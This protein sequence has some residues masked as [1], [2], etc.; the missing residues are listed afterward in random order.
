MVKGWIRL[1]LF[2]GLLLLAACATAPRD[3]VPAPLVETAA[4]PGFNQIRFWGDQP[5]PRIEAKAAAGLERIRAANADRIRRGETVEIDFLALSGGGDN[6]AF[7]A[8]FLNGWTQTGYRPQFQIVTGVSTGAIIAPFAFLGP[9]YDAHLRKAYTEIGPEDV[10][11]AA[12]LPNLIRGPSLASAEP[13]RN[14]INAYTTPSLLREIAVEHRKG[15]RLLVAT[16]NLDAGRSVVWDLGAIAASGNPRSLA[17]FRQVLLASS[18]IPGLLPPV[19]IMVEADGRR[20]TELHADGGVT[21]QV[22]AYQ[23]QVELGQI[24]EAADFDV[25]V[26]IYVIRNGRG[27]P[28]YEPPAKVWYRLMNRSLDVL[29]SHQAMSDI[30]RIFHLAQRDNLR[31]HLALI[32][33]RFGCKPSRPFDQS[34]MQALYRFAETLASSEPAWR[35]HPRGAAGTAGSTSDCGGASGP[36]LHDG[37]V[38]KSRPAIE[39]EQNGGE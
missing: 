15:R 22:F 11:E 7:G 20:F 18:A 19:E 17:L 14:L 3:P 24:L 13:L 30:D 35:D 21:S 36:S 38:V 34:Y 33:R 27:V 39:N 12:L 4:A 28:L 32:P 23:S 26:D 16:T 2:G 31:F 8:G 1:P 9:R 37:A 6:G 29:L 25:A 5:A 10:Y